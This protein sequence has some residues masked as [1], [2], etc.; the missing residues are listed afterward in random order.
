[1][2]ENMGGEEGVSARCKEIIVNTDLLDLEDLR[3]AFGQ[4]VLERCPWRDESARQDRAARET[5][6]R[7]QATTLHLAGGAF[8]DLAEEEHLA[9]AFDR[10]EATGG[11]LT[12]V[13]R[14]RDTGGP[15]HDRRAD[16]LPQCGMRDGKGHS[17]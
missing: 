17:F 5:Q 4:L 11:D 10:G 7:R 15:Q 14:R 9:G 2:P 1:M 13:F 12:Y 16:I 6:F 3:P 8:G